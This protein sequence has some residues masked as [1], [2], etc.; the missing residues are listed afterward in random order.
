MT[1]TT[2]KPITLPNAWPTDGRSRLVNHHIYGWVLAHPE[3]TPHQF[4]NGRWIELQYPSVSRT[5]SL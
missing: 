3:R 1:M 2:D 4:L 5:A